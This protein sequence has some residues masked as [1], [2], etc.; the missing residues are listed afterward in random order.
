MN[1]FIA[2]PL[3]FLAAAVRLAVITPR[4]PPPGPALPADGAKPLGP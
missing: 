4:H 1:P 2:A 3:G